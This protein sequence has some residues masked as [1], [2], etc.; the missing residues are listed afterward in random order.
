M[1][2]FK[3][4]TVTWCDVERRLP[5]NDDYVLTTCMDGSVRDYCF[6]HGPNAEG[7]DEYFE[8]SW[9]EM[10][11]SL[12]VCISGPEDRYVIAWAHRLKGYVNA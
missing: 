9:Y 10:N 2:A 11:G 6:F 3:Q 7:D 12:P 4:E 1:T 5:D 8:Y